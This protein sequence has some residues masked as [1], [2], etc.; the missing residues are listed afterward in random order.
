MIHHMLLNQ[1]LITIITRAVRTYLLAFLSTFK[2]WDTTYNFEHDYEYDS[3]SPGYHGIVIQ[4]S[5]QNVE[6]DD[7]EFQNYYIEEQYLEPPVIPKAHQFAIVADLDINSRDPQSLIWRSLL[8]K[9]ILTKLD[10]G[11]Y[12]IQWQE[13]TILNS[14]TA[15]N[16][17]SMEL[18]E[19]VKWQDNLLAFC[20]YTGMVLI[21]MQARVNSL[22]I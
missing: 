12:T 7:I 20:D 1:T 8:T 17:R 21:T 18:S 5:I 15:T 4:I 6:F 11:N 13:T 16:N 14:S 9:G 19:L 3:N 2:D 22:G 10:T